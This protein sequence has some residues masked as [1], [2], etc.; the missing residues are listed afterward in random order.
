MSVMPVTDL[1]GTSSKFKVGL[2]QS[3][4]FVGGDVMLKRGHSVGA[5][6]GGC[7]V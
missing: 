5:V 4:V 6:L 2:P 1:D 7:E 3:R